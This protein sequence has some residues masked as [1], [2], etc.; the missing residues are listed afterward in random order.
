MWVFCPQVCR[1]AMCMLG[2][3]K[4][5]K[6]KLDLLGWKF[7]WLGATVW[8]LEPKAQCSAETANTFSYWVISPAPWFSFCFIVWGRVLLHHPDW[9]G[10]HCIDQ[11]GLNSQ[12]SA[13]L[14]LLNAGIKGGYH[15]EPS[16]LKLY[17][18]YFHLNSESI[19]KWT[20][21]KLSIFGKSLGVWT[22]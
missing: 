13:C 20:S 21:N 3:R 12:E 15:I 8:M 4:G 2:T 19:E 11:V 7:G 6:R 5:Q 10:I 16:L 22:F 14:S 17:T 18:Y 9:L 1:C